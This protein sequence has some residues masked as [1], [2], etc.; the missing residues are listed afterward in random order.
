MFHLAPSPDG[1]EWTRRLEYIGLSNRLVF[2]WNVTYRSP[3]PKSIR[4]VC[5]YL[6]YCMEWLSYISICSRILF[7]LRKDK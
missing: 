6:M 1:P 4:I 3:L 5:N 7:S 2:Q